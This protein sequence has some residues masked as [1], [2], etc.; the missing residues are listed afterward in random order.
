MLPH[1]VDFAD[2]TVAELNRTEDASMIQTPDV[3]A[4]NLIEE[5]GKTGAYRQAARS[6]YEAQAQGRLYD[7]SIWRDVKRILRESCDAPVT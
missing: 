6:G 1:E 2:F 4:Q 3:I 7:L 5:H